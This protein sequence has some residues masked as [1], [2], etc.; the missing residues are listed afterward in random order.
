M[1]NYNPLLTGYIILIPKIKKIWIEASPLCG[2]TQPA[3]TF[4]NFKVKTEP[5]ISSIMN[6]PTHLGNVPTIPFDPAHPLIP[7]VCG[8]LGSDDFP[9]TF[10]Y[11]FTLYDNNPSGS[12]S[13]DVL[14]APS[15][16]PPYINLII[17]DNSFGIDVSNY[18]IDY[19]QLNAN[20]TSGLYDYGF[21]PLINVTFSDGV[22][23]SPT[24]LYASTPINI[25]WPSLPDPG[26]IDATTTPTYP[27]GDPNGY[28]FGI[29][30]SSYDIYDYNITGE[31]T[32]S[33]RNN[34]IFNMNPEG[35][36]VTNIKVQH[37]I[38]IKAGYGNSGLTIDSGMTIEMGPL[39][40]VVVDNAWYSS[41]QGTFLNL[42]GNAT[43]TAYRGCD[44]SPAVGTDPSTWS[45]ITILGNSTWPQDPSFTATSQGR[46]NLGA[47]TLSYAD[48]AVQVGNSNATSGGE[49][50]SFDMVNFY[51]NKE[52]V[53]IWP[54]SG[55]V[56]WLN[57]TGHFTYDDHASWFIPNDFIS[58]TSVSG[59]GISGSFFTNNSSNPI[60][61]GIKSLDADIKMNG[62]VFN[63]LNTTIPDFRYA[64]LG[65]NV[66]GTHSLYATDCNFYNSTIGTTIYAGT[67]PIIYSSTFNVPEYSGAGPLYYP[68]PGVVLINDMNIGALMQYTSSYTI[69]NNIFQTN[70]TVSLSNPYGYYNNTNGTLEYS[71][72]SNNN[73]VNNNAF[74][75]L[76]V[77]MNSNF[78][79]NNSIA[80]TGLHYVCNTDTRVGI[81]IA[82]VGD[83]IPSGG[84]N[85]VQATSS[86]GTSGFD[87]PAGNYFA[88]QW[89]IFNTQKPF[90]YKYKSPASTSNPQ[91]P[92]IIYTTSAVL[93]YP[94]SASG[95][96]YTLS[97]SGPYVPFGTADGL[98]EG[99]YNVYSYRLAVANVNHYMTDTNGRQHRD[100][101]Y[102]WASQ[103][104]SAYGDLLTTNLL[105]EDGFIDNANLIYNNIIT[106][107]ALDSAEANDFQQGRSIEDVLI[108]QRINGLDLLSLSTDQVATLQRVRANTSMWAHG[109]AEVW[110]NAFEGDAFNDSLLYPQLP[111]TSMDGGR[112][113]ATHDNNTTMSTLQ[114]SLNQ[115]NQVY[116]NPVHDMLQVFYEAKSNDAVTIQIEDLSGRTIVTRR[117]SSGQQFSIDVSS[118]SSGIYIYRIMEGDNVTMIGKIAKD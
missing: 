80:F 69:A 13:Y 2:G 77:A 10:K 67:S 92:S 81:D 107:W 70:A 90:I 78:I 75:G 110:L 62:V 68:A 105:I 89:N 18:Y 113:A 1:D 83:N 19:S 49:V 108:Y 7:P 60:P 48:I 22:G 46:L 82:A 114:K 44:V 42:Y 24:V 88:G 61:Y 21:T 66:S 111:D 71:T 84:I 52:A 85:P 9:Y 5:D 103:M 53:H 55:M 72:G 45:G 57:F 17:L 25:E 98:S 8:G 109:R 59:I 63:G 65:L 54:Y 74:T 95:L 64:F 23:S 99:I 41:W 28:A 102:Y 93:P 32:W 51:N 39:A 20:L 86:I 100:S 97:G 14:S 104:N 31:E 58:A 101:L 37:E 115:E 43:I 112:R 94:L 79:N 27:S 16:T 106:R 96:C 3:G 91:Y 116:P 87:L 117:L 50:R 35:P 11:N 34:P 30:W 4:Y 40:K 12:P 73:V 33:P 47:S 6:M 26:A 38:H 118:L 36:P 29:P 56:W 76:G 15:L